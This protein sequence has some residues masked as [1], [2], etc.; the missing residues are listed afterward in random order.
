M[1]KLVISSMML[2]DRLIPVHYPPKGNFVFSVY[3]FNLFELNSLPPAA[4]PKH[5]FDKGI[6]VV[7]SGVT[8][9]SPIIVLTSTILSI[10]VIDVIIRDSI[11]CFVS[12]FYTTFQNNKYNLNY[13]GYI[14]NN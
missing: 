3:L 12:I 1:K 9:L 4:K 6:I 10:E 14:L 13:T 2:A 8:M 11:G 7:L 5:T